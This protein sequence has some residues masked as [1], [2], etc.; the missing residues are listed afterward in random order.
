MKKIIVLLICCSMVACSPSKD[1]PPIGIADPK[2]SEMSRGILIALCKGDLEGF[3]N[4]YTDDATYRWN[5]GDSLV[6]R[7]AILNYWTERRNSVIDTITFTNE[8]W[9]AIKA[10]NPPEHIKPGVYVLHWADF[11]VIYTNGGSL[12][13]NIHTVFGF[14]D[15]DNVVSTLQYVDRSLIAN[16]LKSSGDSTDSN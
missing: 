3:I 13:M 16:A 1:E 11:K 4:R 5:Y 6:G 15:Q 7:Q 9:L 8:A 2:Y 14:D 12:N 10:N